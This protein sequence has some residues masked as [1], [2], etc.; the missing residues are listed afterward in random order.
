MVEMGGGGTALATF[1]LY[2]CGVLA[3][4][5]FANRLLKR[6]SFLSEYF[7][8]GRSLGVWAFALTFAATSASGGSFT[9]F[10]SKIYSHGWVLALWIGS[11]MVVPICL[12]GLLGK[13]FN[14]VARKSGAITVPD[15]F[16]DRF[17]SPAFGL[18]ATGLIVFFMAF[19][20][21]AQFKA[22]SLILQTLL[23]GTA[24]F[25]GL[26]ADLGSAVGG[27]AMGLS[28]GVDPEYLLCLLVF[29]TIV[30]VYTV[31]GGFHAVV[32]TDVMQGI[33]MV[34]GVMIMLPLALHQAG[35]LESVTKQMGAMTPPRLGV[36]AIEWSSPSERERIVAAGSWG[37]LDGDPNTGRLLR[38]ARSAVLSPGDTRVAGVR[39]VELTTP[40]QIDRVAFDRATNWLPIGTRL[41]RAQVRPYAYG[42]GVEGT[43]VSGPGPSASDPQGFLPLSL[44]F[45][46]FVM[47][48]I[49]GT[50]QPGNYVRLMAFRDSR[51]L[52]HSIATVTIYYSLIYF[53]LILIFCCARVLLPGMEAE[54][55]RI[56]PAMV[57]FLTENAGLAWLG[58]LVVAAPFAA[59]MSTVDSFLLMISSALVRDIYQHNLRPD[60]DEVRIRRF[61]YAATLVVG[62]AAVIGAVDPPR[63]LQD[64]IVYTGSGLAA[65]FLGPTVFALYWPRVN[66]VGA[67]SGMIAGFGAHLAMYIAGAFVNGSFFRPVRI[68]DLDPILVGLTVSF[69]AIWLVTRWTARPPPDLVHRYFLA[70]T[71]TTTQTSAQ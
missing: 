34:S 24:S 12:M 43:Y 64:I 38:V 69:A 16:R 52:R 1:T 50:G 67:M 58:G 13:R 36:A 32:W 18:L 54:S 37:W 53:P 66:T 30:I 56:M 20:L 41:T 5:W 25:H 31:Y 44:A 70:G 59:V 14:Q 21:I 9:G 55:D 6:R 8:G 71:G 49:A 35:G 42:D 60:A 65:C 23:A 10:P 68:F 46:F 26:A 29:G 28:S 45:S 63:F 39:V 57:I 33:V 22:G 4:A 7:L 48:A 51:T 40:G 27:G 61:S 62:V 11:Y 47:W 3:L 15:V 19:N 17:E 2:V